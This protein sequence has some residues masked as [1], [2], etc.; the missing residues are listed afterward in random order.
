MKRFGLF[1]SVLIMTI[2]MSGVVNAWAGDQPLVS[3]PNLGDIKGSY[4]EITLPDGSVKKI[5]HFSAIPYAEPMTPANRWQPAMKKKPFK[6]TPYD[7][8]VACPACPQFS[9]EKNIQE[10]C[11]YLRVAAPETA[12]PGSKLPVMVFIHGGAFMTGSA[13]SDYYNSGASITAEKDVIVVTIN[14]RLG[15]LGFMVHHGQGGTDTSHGNFGIGDQRLAVEFVKE[16]IAAFGGDANNI[17]I[18]GESA[19]AMSIGFHLMMKDQEY[20]DAAIMQSN[21]YGLPYLT[22]KESATLGKKALAAAGCEDLACMRE[23]TWKDVMKVGSGLTAGAVKDYG[24]KGIFCF[25]PVIEDQTFGFKTQPANH[26]PEKPVVLGINRNE[27]PLIALGIMGDLIQSTGIKDLTA[28][29]EDQFDTLINMLFM[30]K[31]AQRILEPVKALYP[32]FM[33]ES[34]CS[35]MQSPPKP[36]PPATPTKYYTLF[37]RIL[38]DMVFTSANLKY[39]YDAVAGDQ[40]LY[41]YHFTHVS[42][43]DPWPILRPQCAECV[44]HT[45]ELPYLFSSFSAFNPECGNT[46]SWARIT[47]R[48]Y[49]LSVRMMDF[50][51]RFAAQ[52]NPGAPWPEFEGAPYAAQLLDLNIDPTPV[53]ATVLGAETFYQLYAPIV[54]SENM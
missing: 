48:E 25:K 21:L 14:Y 31:N 28:M 30:D 54:E 35:F 38:S 3:V 51:T 37:T 19:G 2:L 5:Q 45:A 17:T 15:I 46:D 9:P 11:L 24:L 4:E 50:W 6:T 23:K 43:C 18:F 22:E 8:T 12:K 7:A 52:R 16:H 20:F 10:D 1:M 26:V 49:G 29:T 33:K 39:A 27:G 53:K 44:C 32:A 41:A 42:S 34:D 40:P 13:N 36:A 47:P